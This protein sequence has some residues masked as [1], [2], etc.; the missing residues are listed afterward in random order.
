MADEAAELAR[1]GESD[2][3]I[4]GAVMTEEEVDRMRI[5]SWWKS[6]SYRENGNA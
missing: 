3:P 2:G 1:A 6:F 4:E 5:T